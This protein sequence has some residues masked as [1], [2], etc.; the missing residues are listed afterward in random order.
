MEVP[1]SFIWIVIFFEETF[2]YGNGAKIWGH[3]MQK[4]KISSQFNSLT[5]FV[6]EFEVLLMGI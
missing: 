3:K 6:I 4:G 2:K 5:P 1:T